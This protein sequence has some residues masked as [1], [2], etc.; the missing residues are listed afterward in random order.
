MMLIFQYLSQTKMSRIHERPV[1]EK[2]YIAYYQAL[3]NLI[4]ISDHKQLNFT[5]L[6][7]A[8]AQQN[9]EAGNALTGGTQTIR[10]MME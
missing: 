1:L 7:I 10:N 4:N 6:Q 8:V 3:E 2:N 5:A 9:N